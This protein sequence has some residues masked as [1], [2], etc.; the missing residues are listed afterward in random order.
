LSISQK[1]GLYTTIPE[2]DCLFLVITKQDTMY[3]V[4]L[5]CS[6]NSVLSPM[7]EGYFRHYKQGDAEVYGTGITLKKIDPLAVKIMQEDKID[8]S[9]L[10]HH[11]LS[12][13]RHIDFD[14]IL[15]FDADSEAESHHLPSKSVKYHFYFDKLLMMDNAE[16]TDEIFRNLRNQ[17]KKAIRSFIKEHF[18]NIQ[19]S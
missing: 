19:E 11:K 10:D 6:D 16:S 12:D 9:H 17:I 5:L 4:L 1:S 8:I 13:L 15:T 14:Y 3:Q 2:I 18:T 7:A